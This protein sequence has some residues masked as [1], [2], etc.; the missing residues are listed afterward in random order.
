MKDRPIRVARVITRLNVGGPAQQAILL[1]AGLDSGCFA[2]TL[3]TGRPGPDE[4]DLSGFALSRGVTPIS[5]PDLGRAVR[6]AG[7]L[8]A[9]VRLIRLFREIRPDIVHTHTAKAGTLGRLAARV[10]RVPV[11]IHTFHGH[12]LDGYFSA[13]VTRVFLEIERRLARK[14]TRLVTLAPGLRDALL[15][16][17][18]G[19]PDQIAVIPL[20]LELERF[21]EACRGGEAL[22]R[23]LDIPAGA[24][25]LGSI[26]RL[27]PIKDHATLFR[28]L[29]RPGDVLPMH[30]LV[31]GDGECRGDLT[32][33]AEALGIRSQVHFLGWRSD[34]EAILDATD[35]IVS[36]SRNEGTPVALIEAMAAGV[37]VVATA[38]GGV[39]DL[40]QHDVTGWLVPPGDPE[41]LAG[42]IRRLVVAPTIRAR[43]AAAAR[44]LALDRHGARG[45]IR[46]VEEL[47][48]G[49]LA[50]RKGR[51]CAF[52]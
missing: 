1:A 31:A 24:T 40:V 43:L 29:A 26:G 25:V 11:T 46:R 4:G 23:A 35:M 30:L 20:G 10:A 48:T 19:L 28:A 32:R 45:L 14:T 22:R 36:S 52:S 44:P 37:P 17:R 47:Y 13:P 9:L 50:D 6:P 5:I 12:V 42:A 8:A 3:I 7:D 16:M 34:L 38:V 51:V 15:A 21:A 27:V 41:A 49:V 33:L 18:I 2:T 39:P